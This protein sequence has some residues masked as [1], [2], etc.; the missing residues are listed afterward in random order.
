MQK[1]ESM[2]ERTILASRWLLL[3]FYVGLGIGLAVYAFSFS[4]KLVVLIRSVF[5]YSG[6]EMILSM[7]GLIDAALVAS[8]LVMVMLSGYETFI[9]RLDEA[10][11]HLGWLSKLDSA[12]LK[13]KLAASIV[14]ISSIH[15]LQVFLNLE[16]YQNDKILWSTLIH[17]TFLMSALLLGWLDR[18]SST[19]A[20]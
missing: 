17:I 9:S 19:K 20:H 8:L 10:G 1:L 5:T 13:V 6:N 4:L 15:L 16:N 7:L 14:A 12:S 18:V 2:I 3:V 11:E